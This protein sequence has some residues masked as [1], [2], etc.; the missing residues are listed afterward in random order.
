MMPARLTSSLLVRKGQAR[1][2]GGPD[3]PSY[4]LVQPLADG[5]ALTRPTVPR[6]PMVE[7]P[8]GGPDA[9]SY[10]LVQPLADGGALTRLAVPRAPMV[11]ILVPA[12]LP[13]VTTAGS[14]RSGEDDPVNLT[15]RVD[16]AM[17]T[18]LRVLAARQQRTNR[19]IV[20]CA[21]DAYLDAFAAGCA[22]VEGAKPKP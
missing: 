15:V 19:D 1:P 10:G 2:S 8:S 21:L 18:R 13:M 14:G 16:R 5:G 17:R 3:A 6:T 20:R 11:E 22:C 4:G 9:P 12:R 7:R